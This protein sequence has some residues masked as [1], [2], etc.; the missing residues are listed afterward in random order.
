MRTNILNKYILSF[1]F[2]GISSFSVYSQKAERDNIKKG[3]KMYEK[4]K[5]IEAEIDYRKSLEVNPNSIDAAFNLG[6]ALFKQEKFEDALKQYS[7]A[8]ETAHDNKIISEALH[9]TG[10]SLMGTHNFEKA[11]EAY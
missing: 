5:Y 6:N 4:E 11:I 2:L 7:I 3:N 10:N 1:I 8:A 9:N